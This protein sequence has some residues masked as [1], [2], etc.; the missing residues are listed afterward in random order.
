[1]L[2]EGSARLRGW[3]TM[4]ALVVKAVAALARERIGD[5]AGLAD[6]AMRRRGWFA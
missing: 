6:D 3:V 2:Y 5:Y 1:M 4:K